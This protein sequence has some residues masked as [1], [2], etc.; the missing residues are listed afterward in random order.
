MDGSGHDREGLSVRRFLIEARLTGPG[1]VSLTGSEAHHARNV[2]RLSPGDRVLL[3]DGSGRQYRAVLTSLDRT[4]VE[5]EALEEVP[6]PEEPSMRLTLGLALLKADHLDLVVQKSTE[7]GLH[8]LVPLTTE[9][10]NVRLTPE[11]AGQKVARWQEI[12]RQSLKQCGR[13]QAVRIEPVASLDDFLEH[14]AGASLKILL[15]TGTG[16]ARWSALAELLDGCQEV[17]SVAVLVGPEGGFTAEEATR[18]QAC[19]FEPVRLGPRIMR[20]ETAALAI[21]SILGFELGDLA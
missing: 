14:T 20:G 10:T 13:S 19:G 4:R 6:A 15:H 3:M 7:L 16:V 18:A 12:S 1:P 21:M 9:L 11:R 5:L 2:L 8:T 17:L